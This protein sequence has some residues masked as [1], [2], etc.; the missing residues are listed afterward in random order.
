M[1]RSLTFLLIISFIFTF[2]V[3]FDI[4]H[5]VPPLPSS[6]YGTVKLNGS[7][8]P[9]GTTVE[10]LINGEVIS[11]AK[12]LIYQ[13]DSVYAIDVS[14]DDSSTTAVEGGQEEDI[15]QFRV[16]GLM[17]NETGIWRSG[18][19]VELN[20]NITASASPEPP[21]T[22]NTPVPSQTSMIAPTATLTMEPT[23]QNTTQSTQTQASGQ[24]NNTNTATENILTT[25]ETEQP[26]T[27]EAS[28]TLEPDPKATETSISKTDDGSPAPSE[29]EI[30]QTEENE[31]PDDQEQ[32]NPQN[33]LT[34]A[35]IGIVSL[36]VISGVI[37][38]IVR[39]QRNK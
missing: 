24:V 5:A 39:R 11:F 27:N 2:F 15:I 7:N 23:Q 38:W 31:G 17:A 35:L 25:E 14:G 18:T 34:V 20:L 19:N 10:A 13:G 36:A 28:E 12:T 16:G 33:F 8:L 32:D 9:E 37:F 26:S 6:F 1:R 22:T 29:D 30:L 4:V 21:E 3:S